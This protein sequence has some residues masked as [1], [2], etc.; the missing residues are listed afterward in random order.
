MVLLRYVS[1]QHSRFPEYWGN[2]IVSTLAAG[3]LVVAVAALGG[4]DLLRSPVPGLLIMIAIGDC[5][6][7]RLTDCAGQ[8]FQAVERLRITAFLN[9]FT[10]VLRL[11]AAVFLWLTRGNAT[12]TVWAAASLVV[13]GLAVVAAVIAV[14]VK[15]GRPR[16]LSRLLFDRLGEGFGF[17]IAYSTTS[18]YNDI[19]KAMLTR[20]GMY[21]ANGAYSVAYRIIDLACLPVRALHAAALPHFFRVGAGTPAG[22]AAFCTASIEADISLG[23]LR[24]NR[25][26]RLRPAR[27][28]CPRK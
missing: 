21:A 19:D 24:G 9:A 7:A 13:S 25:A 2:A 28:S 1:A 3:L 4:T 23:N 8:A 5:M 10:S 18:I 11:S 22:G 17:S 6:F 12:A 14:T 27:G 15:I 16:F 26:V 20:Y